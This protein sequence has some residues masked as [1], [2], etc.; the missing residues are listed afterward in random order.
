MKRSPSDVHRIADG[1]NPPL[2]NISGGAAEQAAYQADQ[3]DTVSFKADGFREFFQRERR[4]GV[5]LAIAGVMHAVRSRDHGVNAIEF[6][7]QSVNARVLHKSWTSSA[8]A[9]VTSACGIKVFNSEIETAGRTR[10]NRNMQ[11]VKK[12]SVPRRIDQSFQVG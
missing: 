12:P 1:I 11:A 8:C 3:R 9:T 4:V 6:R 10:R 7:Q 2:Q 5:D